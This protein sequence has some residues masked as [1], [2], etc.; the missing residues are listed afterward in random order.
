MKCKKV[1]KSFSDCN[2]IL[3]FS[4]LSKEEDCIARDKKFRIQLIN[5]S[6]Y[7]WYAGWFP[8]KNLELTCWREHIF[9]T[10]V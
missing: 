10:L 1:N 6:R 7:K 3:S 4:T 8:Y 9:F 5:V 2:C